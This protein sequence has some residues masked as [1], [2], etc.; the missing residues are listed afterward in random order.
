LTSESV[1]TFVAKGRPTQRQPKDL[2]YVILVKENAPELLWQA[3]S[4]AVVDVVGTGDYQPQTI[5][6]SPIR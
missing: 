2:A 6:I 1:V 5:D 4:R 3:L